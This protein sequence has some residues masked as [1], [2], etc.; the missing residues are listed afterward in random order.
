MSDVIAKAFKAIDVAKAQ[1]RAEDSIRAHMLAAHVSMASG[2]WA[3]AEHHLTVADKTSGVEDG[4]FWRLRA[5]L[6]RAFAVSAMSRRDEAASIARQ[7]ASVADRVGDLDAL[8]A[9]QMV[10]F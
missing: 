10:G 7:V 6:D 9:S 2:K 5:S 3:L 1:G 4:N 8:A